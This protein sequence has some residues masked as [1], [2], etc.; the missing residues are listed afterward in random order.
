MTRPFSAN[1]DLAPITDDDVSVIARLLREKSGIRVLPAQSSML[2]SR[3]GRRLRGLGMATFRDYARFVDTPEGAAELKDM[4]LALT[5]NVTHFFREAHHFDLLSA[6]VLPPLIQRARQK[7][8]I[9]LWSAGSS[10]GQEPYSIAMCLAK[11]APDL[12][13]LDIRILATDIDTTVLQSADR[14]VY[15]QEV[16]EHV[17]PEFRNRFFQ[18]TQDGFRISDGIHS[19]VTFRELNL[20]QDWPMKGKFDVIFCRNVAIYFDTLAQNRLWQRLG[21]ALTADG[22]LF[23]GHS[24]RIPSDVQTGLRSSGV[25]VYRRISANV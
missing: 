5:T 23:L 4:I 21:S 7:E 13:S 18:R 14:G 20:H 1:A 25:T 19:I 10:S 12:A 9:R 3:L 8:R 2:Q 15:S 17:P 24:E 11:L 22:W 6:T 16:M